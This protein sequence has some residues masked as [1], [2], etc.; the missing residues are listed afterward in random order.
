MSRYMMGLSMVQ[1][2]GLPFPAHFTA[3]QD[4]RQ[5]AKVL[6][7]LPQLLLLLLCGTIAGADD[8]VELNLWGRAP[9]VPASFP[10]VRAAFRA[11][12]G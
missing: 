12:T 2:A 4:P 3:L 7:P 1:P 10:A 8:F 9:A 6:Y 11:M 5:A